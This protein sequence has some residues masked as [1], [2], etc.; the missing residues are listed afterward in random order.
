M[1]SFRLPIV[2]I[3][4]GR[5]K[6]DRRDSQRLLSID[7]D[8]DDEDDA[9]QHARVVIDRQALT[10]PQLDERFQHVGEEELRRRRSCWRTAG[11]HCSNWRSLASEKCNVF[12]LLCSFF[13]ILTWC[14]I[15][16]PKRC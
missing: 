12:S 15:V 16:I 9:I 3:S 13:P 2:S 8:E 7:D 5:E 11:R 1:P 6:R 10:Q 14:V 4:N